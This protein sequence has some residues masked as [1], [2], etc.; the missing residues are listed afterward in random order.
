MYNKKKSEKKFL[1][2]IISKDEN[3]LLKKIKIM[4]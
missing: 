4:K 2:K 3:I 1:E